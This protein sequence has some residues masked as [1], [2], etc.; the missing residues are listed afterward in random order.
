MP[1][2]ELGNLPFDEAID[3]F[4]SKLNIPTE[5]FD[6][7]LSEAHAKAFTVAGATKADLLGD[8]R[9]AV[10]EAI[11]NG[12]SITE[13]RKQFDTAVQKHGWSYKGKR[14][15]RTRV[16]Y[17]NNLRSAHMAGRWKQLQRTK[18]GRP[19]LT[20]V[21]V[22]DGRVRPQHKS[23]E[24]TTLPIDD[25]WWQTHYPPNGWGCRCTIRSLSQRQLEAMGRGVSKRP[26][27]NL[28]ERINVASGEIYGDVP[29]GI[30][31]GWDYNVGKAWLGPDI[32]FGEKIMSLPTTMRNAALTSARDLAPHLST[33]FN[34]WATSLMNRQRPLNEIRTVG[35]LSPAVVDDLVARK[36]A[37]TTAVVTVTDRDVMHMLRDSKDG[38]HIPADIIRALPDEISNPSAVLWDKRDP[39]LLYVVDV[40]G[41]IRDAKLVVRVNFKTK[42]RGR[43]QKRHSMVTNAVRTGGL[44]ELHN[45]RDSSIYEVIEGKI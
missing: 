40:P 16:I 5:H 37:P 10:D 28:T 6:S 43:D 31:V 33:Q 14:G 1:E 18:D 7:L 25:S 13:F 3:H 35:Y 20:Y 24:G 23:W 27:L 11:A 2:V 22:G 26:N 34:P 15:W 44:V 32:A 9:S 42:A 12:T 29:A 19:Y 8:I 39:A 41:D 17:D 30:D 21:T 36:Q 4:R 38:K 45:L